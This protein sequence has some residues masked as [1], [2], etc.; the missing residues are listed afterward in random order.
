[1]KDF[2]KVFHLE[3]LLFEISRHPERCLRK[4]KKKEKKEA[5]ERA[6]CLRSKRERE[7]ERQG[8]QGTGDAIGFVRKGK[9]AEAVRQAHDGDKVG[10]DRGV[11]KTWTERERHV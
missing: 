4:K 9:A 5:I 7:R 8:R 2:R 6:F 11:G 10:M 1:M 3:M